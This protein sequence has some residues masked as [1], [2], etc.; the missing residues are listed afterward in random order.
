[1][2]SV[3][4]EQKRVAVDDH[5]S[6]FGA[7]LAIRSYQG[8]NGSTSVISRQARCRPMAMPVLIRRMHQRSAVASPLSQSA[9]CAPAPD[10]APSNETITRKVGVTARRSSQR[11]LD[12]SA[13]RLCGWGAGQIG[14]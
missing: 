9:S 4:T 10:Q 6:D 5:G 14:H 12:A 3:C 8:A 7:H 1:M 11:G 2:K 13:S